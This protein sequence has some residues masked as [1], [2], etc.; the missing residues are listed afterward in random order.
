MAFIG[1][2]VGT[3]GCK[4]SVMDISGRISDYRYQEYTLTSS[5]HGYAE[6]DANL[7]WAAVKNV[8]Q[9]I[10][11]DHKD[12]SA[13]AIASFGEAVVLLDKYDRVLDKSIFYSDI[14]GTEEVSDILSHFEREI[15]QELTGMPINPM[16]SANKL[17]WIKKHK[18]DTYD[19]AVKIMLFG[20]YIAYMLTGEA[21]VD[22]SLASRTMLLNIKKETWADEFADGLGLDT[23]RFSRLVRSGDPIAYI[24]PKVS[25][26]LGFDNKVLLIAGGHDQPL[27]ALGAGAVFAGDS[28][29]FDLVSHCF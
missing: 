23:S 28:V 5:K 2:D 19:K 1:L 9:Q 3:A 10:A 11:Q 18:R 14:R 27:A 26:E 16:Y 29:D 24:S 4:A 13:L 21:A 20:D 6:I 17:L 12:I 8:L 25:A 15:V 22:F 7:V